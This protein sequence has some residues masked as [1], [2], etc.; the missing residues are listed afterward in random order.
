MSIIFIAILI[1]YIFIIGQSADEQARGTNSAR[2]D[3]D[4]DHDY[5]GHV[6]GDHDHDCG[7]HVHGK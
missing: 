6:H 2:G 1:N 4:H 5:G 7:D 3:S